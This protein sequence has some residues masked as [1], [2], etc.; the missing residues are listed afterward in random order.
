MQIFVRV[1]ILFI[2]TFLY[3][4]CITND[5]GDTSPAATRSDMNEPSSWDM[6]NPRQDSERDLGPSAHDLDLGIST[7]M[8]EDMHLDMPGPAHQEDLGK[9]MDAEMGCN[10][11]CPC[12]GFCQNGV[13]TLHGTGEYWDGVCGAEPECA[14][15]Q[16]YQ[17]PNGCAQGA[18][19]SDLDSSSACEASVRVGT[20]DD[21]SGFCAPE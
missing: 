9:D 15:S 7:E 1:T 6:S 10:L 14:P 21:W 16:T 11:H 8:N 20:Y 2:L 12:G 3:S 18:P 5:Q 17:C 19:S 13:V 4:G